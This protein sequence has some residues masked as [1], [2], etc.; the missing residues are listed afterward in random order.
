MGLMADS[1]MGLPK[2]P[3]GSWAMTT[4]EYTTHK[5]FKNLIKEKKKKKALL[6]KCQRSTV[7]TTYHLFYFLFFGN[8]FED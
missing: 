3:N 1:S 6:G 2:S 7:T 5:S 4:H 8:D